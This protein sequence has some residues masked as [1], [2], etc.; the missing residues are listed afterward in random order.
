MRHA[1]VYIETLRDQA[2][3]EY[4]PKIREAM[5]VGADA[6]HEVKRLHSIM[7]K[8]G[9]ECFM[10]SGSPE[11]VAEH[12]KR[13]AKSWQLENSR[14]IADN[15]RLCNEVNHLR[16]VVEGMKQESSNDF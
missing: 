15:I 16:V 13:I 10:K 3:R 1:E 2:S 12:M 14:L 8:A 6:I 4:V 9:L 7:K 5:L 11:E